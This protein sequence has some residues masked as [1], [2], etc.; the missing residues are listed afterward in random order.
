VAMGFETPLLNV[1]LCKS[2]NPTQNCFHNIF[3]A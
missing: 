2:K 1:S 3:L